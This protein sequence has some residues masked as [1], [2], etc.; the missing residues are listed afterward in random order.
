MKEKLIGGKGGRRAWGY[1][2]RRTFAI[3]GGYHS[4]AL[5]LGRKTFEAMERRYGKEG[6]IPG[7]GCKKARPTSRLEG[8]LA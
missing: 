2:S 1:Q 8:G 5:G 6:G 4:G 7:P 3:G